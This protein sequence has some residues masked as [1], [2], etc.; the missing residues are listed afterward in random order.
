VP[1]RLLHLF[2]NTAPSQLD[3]ERG[4]PYIARR[5]LRTLDPEG[6]S[7]GARNLPAAAWREGAKAR[8]L[9][10]DVRVLAENLARASA[11]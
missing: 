3:V 10:L 8:G 7:W 11:E 5:L 9:A 6:L 1:S 2:W 4:G